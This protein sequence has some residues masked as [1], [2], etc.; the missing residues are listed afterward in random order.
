MADFGGGGSFAASVFNFSTSVWQATQ[1]ETG[2]DGSV[3]TAT[4]GTRPNKMTEVAKS[5]FMRQLLSVCAGFCVRSGL[6]TPTTWAEDGYPL[7]KKDIGETMVIKY[8][9]FSSMV[10]AAQPGWASTGP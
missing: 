8:N 2:R 5:L 4:P 1:E 9:C 7:L 10:Q 3:A 6:L